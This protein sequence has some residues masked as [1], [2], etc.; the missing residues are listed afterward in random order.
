MA[1]YIRRR[2][3]IF[4]LGGAAAAWP[5]AA[6][7]QQ[8]RK[9]P[10]VG[11]LGATTPATAGQWIAAFAQHL[12]E[13]GWT[14]G[15]TVAIEYRFAEGRNE[16]MAEIVTE[17]VR[18]RADVIVAQGTQAALTA[19]NATAA[20]PIVFVLPGDPVGSGLVAS[21]ARP[22][23]NVTGLSSQT[24]DLSGK[25]L[26]LL[27]EIVPGLRR[28]AMMGNA[29]NPANVSDMHEFQTAARASGLDATTFEIR[30][31]ED[32]T[33]AFAAFK[34]KVDA[35][36]VAPDALLNTNRMRINILALAARLPT[37]Y[38]A[39]ENVE[40]G[41]ISYGPSFTDLFR[42]AGDYVDKILRGTRPA[43]LPVE[44]PTKFELVVNLI[45]AMAL[46]LD[47]PPSLLARADEVIE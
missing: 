1:T 22:G 7:A 20:I 4:T 24:T 34:G 46:G 33:A 17:F 39:R 9:T 43:D 8:P 38:G 47:V 27:R 37:M 6:R 23:G 5:L 16:R 28:L 3:F 26:D 29:G 21:L 25:R 36:Y 12:N 41:L 42:R 31:T 35:L 32:I 18:A 11:L 14:E 13:L 19:K 40:A 45:T 30:R 10:T 2:E 15:R 44:Q